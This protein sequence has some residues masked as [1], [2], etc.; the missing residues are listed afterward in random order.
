MARLGAL[1]LGGEKSGLFEHPAASWA[2]APMED[3]S[4]LLNDMEGE[5]GGSMGNVELW[6]N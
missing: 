6:G 1:G 5:G 4:S 2:S 3:S